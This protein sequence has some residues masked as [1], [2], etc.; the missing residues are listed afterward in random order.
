[1][2]YLLSGFNSS[3][4]QKISFSVE[5]GSVVDLYLEFRSQQRGWF[6]DLVWGRFVLRGQRIS[7]HPN[8]LRPFNR[9]IPFG[10]SVFSLT[11]FEPQTLE[12]LTDGTTSLYLLLGD[13][14]TAMEDLIEK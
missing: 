11:A 14:V 9:T 4:K 8:I 7:N 3:P 10:L 13:S 12:C 1:M 5:D 6:F 2:N